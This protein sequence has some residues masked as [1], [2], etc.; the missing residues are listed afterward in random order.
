LEYYDVTS[1]SIPPSNPSILSRAEFVVTGRAVIDRQGVPHQ[2][3]ALG[4]V[5]RSIGAEWIAIIRKE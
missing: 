1:A 5:Y 2:V 3:E 4:P